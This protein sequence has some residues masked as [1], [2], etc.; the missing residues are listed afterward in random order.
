MVSDGPTCMSDQ[1]VQD[2]SG[3]QWFLETFPGDSGVSSFSEIALSRGES[4]QHHT[5][6][7][8]DRVRNMKAVS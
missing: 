4:Y 1:F 3:H 5:Y 8:R 2:F 6:T 7:I